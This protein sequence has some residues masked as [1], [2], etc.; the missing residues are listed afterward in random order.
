MAER[1][2]QE[3]E[4][5]VF[6]YALAAAAVI[7]KGQMVI[8]HAGLAK[9]ASAIAAAKSVGIAQASVDQAAGDLGVNAK[10]GTFLMKNSAGADEITAADVLAD[11]FVVDGE[12]V[13]KTS[14]T[15]A[16]PVA[17]RIEQIEGSGVWVTFA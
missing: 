11:C 15:D 13:A 2:T 1:N 10:R 5:S 9:P 16:R 4:G 7:S 8:L 6:N 12:T 17:G 3:R 14:D